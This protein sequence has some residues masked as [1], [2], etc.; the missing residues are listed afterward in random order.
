MFYKVIMLSA[1][2]GLNSFAS[3]STAKKIH[4]TRGSAVTKYKNMVIEL[5]DAG[6]HFS[7][8]PWMKEYLT[9]SNAKF[10]SK[11]ERAFE[12]MVAVVGPRQFETLP[13]RSLKKQKSNSLY[14]IIAKKS[15][16]AGKYKTAINYAKN[17]NPNH[18][19]RPFASN[20]LGAANANLGRYEASL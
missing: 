7:A 20:L 19:I 15:M 2:I 6:F 13:L 16:R 18:P 10:D 17:I 14:Y 5:V 9:R 12:E 4:D 11:L 8:I 3:V 1:L